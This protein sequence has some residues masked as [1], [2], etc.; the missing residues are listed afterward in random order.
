MTA[1][2]PREPTQPAFASLLAVLD[3]DRSPAGRQLVAGVCRAAGDMGLPAL[4]VPLDVASRWPRPPMPPTVGGTLLTGLIVIGDQTRPVTVPDN[5]RTLPIVIIDGA[6]AGTI[7]AQVR[8]DYPASVARLLRHLRELGHRR[9]GYVG[10]AGAGDG[11]DQW[12]R[13]LARELILADLFNPEHFALDT[14]DAAGGRASAL[15]LL[16]L[17]QPPTVLICRNGRMA[18]GVYRAAAENQIPVPTGLSVVA[19]DDSDV[20]PDDLW[21]P[22]DTLHTPYLELGARAVRMILDLTR[23]DGSGEDLAVDVGCDL[24]SRSSTARIQHEDHPAG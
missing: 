4:L 8:V 6:G 21:P 15:R 3:L 19:V 23:G 12:Q 9:I 16:R 18:M 5:L 10:E 24:V 17:R 2:S 11:P 14:P 20:T 7:K 22:L 13:A 1:S